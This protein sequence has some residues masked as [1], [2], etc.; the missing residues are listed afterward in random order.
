VSR[1]RRG[2]EI[3]EYELAWL[4]RALT[5]DQRDALIDAGWDDVAAM[6]DF[7]MRRLPELRELWE[8]RLARAP[9]GLEDGWQ[10]TVALMFWDRAVP[11]LVA[12]R[13]QSDVPVVAVAARA[14][15][16]TRSKQGKWEGKGFSRGEVNKVGEIYA[17]NSDLTPWEVWTRYRRVRDPDDD[18]NLGKDKVADLLAELGDG[19][20]WWDAE[21]ELV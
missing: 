12:N 11:L 4:A 1:L 13:P 19:T 15:E 3:G 7:A 18:G 5:V 20:A 21:R 8:T 9:R 10:R 14:R 17:R 6:F 16:S 2:V